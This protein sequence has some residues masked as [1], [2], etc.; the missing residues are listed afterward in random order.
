MA[1]E[2]VVD[3]Y[4]AMPIVQAHAFFQLQI[5]QWLE[6]QSDGAAARAAALVVAM[7]GLLQM[8]VIDLDPTDDANI[9]LRR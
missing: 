5:R 1:N 3:G 2:L 7:I 4:D 8:V 6:Q 9:I